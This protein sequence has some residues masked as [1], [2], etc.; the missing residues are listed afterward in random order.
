MG[1][2]NKKVFRLIVQMV[3]GKNFTAGPAA[4]S[5]DAY[6]EHTTKKE[7]NG[8]V[9]LD[10]NISRRGFGDYKP[11]DSIWRTLMEKPGKLVE[12]NG[13]LVKISKTG[14][15]YESK[16][17]VTWQFKLEKILNFRG[18]SK[19]E[20]EKYL[21]HYPKFIRTRWKNEPYFPDGYKPLVSHLKKLKV[22]ISPDDE[23]SNSFTKYSQ[24][25]R[26]KSLFP[27]TQGGNTFVY[28][29]PKLREGDFKDESELDSKYLID[30]ELKNILERPPTER[31][32]LESTI[33]NIIESK[34]I[35][36]QYYFVSEGTIGKRRFDF[37]LKIK[38]ES[39]LQL[40]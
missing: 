22:A 6:Y 37:F 13:S 16:R 25:S 40:K 33:H 20:K 4:G 23:R 17:G 39:I 5:G 2:R 8:K 10:I 35:K 21:K 32:V 11:D 1:D 27:I 14:Y 28:G 31:G 15:I 18:M 26:N 30:Q 7:S 3:R 19:T 38:M 34:L 36:K 12:Y 9:I 24:N 29:W